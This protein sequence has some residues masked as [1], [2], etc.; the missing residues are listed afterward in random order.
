MALFYPRLSEMRIGDVPA[1]LQWSTEC[2]RVIAERQIAS[3]EYLIASC[4]VVEA[5][6]QAKDSS[7]SQA[8]SYLERADSL[9]AQ[10]SETPKGSYLD[11]LVFRTLRNE[12]KV[13][14]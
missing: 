9:V 10:T 1:T 14:N 4:L 12:A 11:R 7:F 13:E 2:Q 6:A 5:L 8:A 3:R